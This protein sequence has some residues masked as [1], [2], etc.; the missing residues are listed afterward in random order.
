MAGRYY[1]RAQVIV[2]ALFIPQAIV[3]YNSES[4]L[5]YINQPEESA[6]YAGEYLR[7]CMYGIWAY[8]QTELLRRF[9]GTQGVFY[10]ILNV[11]IFST[12]M[13]MVWLYLFVYQWD[14][15]I[16]GVAYSNLITYSMNFAI[17]YGYIW[18]N[19]SVVKED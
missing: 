19:K 4:I 18:I 6:K 15:G 8:C 11:Q 13:H 17:S 9:L 10:L 2:S 7:I 5:L 16:Y 14:W 1:T 3:L 12:C